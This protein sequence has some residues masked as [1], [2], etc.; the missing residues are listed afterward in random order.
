MAEGNTLGYAS[1]DTTGH[2]S[3]Y[4]FTRREVGPLDIRFK[5]THCGI[6]H[7]DI[8]VIRNEWK[9]AHYPM[10]PGHEIVGVVTEVG[11]KATKFKVGDHVGA[12]FLIRSCVDCDLCNEDLHQYCQKAVYTF[13]AEDYDGTITQGG[14]SSQMV[15][16]ERFAVLVPDSLPLAA[17][18]PLLCAGITVYSPMKRFQMDVPGKTF[19]VIGLGGLGHMAVKFG[20]AFGMKVVVLS[21]SP[22][23]EKEA[24]EVLG[25][26]E[27]LVT[28]DEA[29]MKA[30]V[31]TIDFILDTVSAKHEF[32]TYLPLLKVHGKLVLVGLPE[33][34]FV[35]NAFD[36]VSGGKTLA[37]SL[38]GGINQMQD[39]MYFCEKHNVLP[40]IETVPIDYVNTAMERLIKSDIKYR[41]VIDIEGSLK[42]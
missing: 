4:K 29:A 10:V 37:G 13:N 6:C 21:T 1:F 19:G 9:N 31:G 8:H 27:F 33:E 11:S 22:R 30:N 20:K 32:S 16:D 26:D 23:K 15:C 12:G 41:F 24:L 39:M 14:Y 3:P 40:L 17:A 7:T 38:I 28:K 42:A 5:V 25:A 34:P 35:L 18:A 36:I 2:L